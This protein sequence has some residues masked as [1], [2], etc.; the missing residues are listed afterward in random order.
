MD[1]WIGLGKKRAEPAKEMQPQAQAHQHMLV[2][3]PFA[4][5]KA[6]LSGDVISCHADQMQRRFC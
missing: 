5:L 4:Q 1:G 6:R 2:I 3:W